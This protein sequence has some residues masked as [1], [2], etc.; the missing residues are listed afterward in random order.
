[1]TK[2]QL[3]EV[4]AGEIRIRLADI[5]GADLTDESRSEL[6]LLRTE[7][8]DVERRMGA[9]RI[10][11]TPSTPTSTDTSE[12]R[13]FRGLLT[14]ANAGAIF[15]SVVNHNPIAGET[16]ELQQHY[17]LAGNMVPLAL[18]AR[19]LPEDGLETRAA[20]VTNAPAD[21]GQNQQSI[22]PY[23][24][25]D[26]VGVFLGVD[27]PTVGVGETVFPVLTTA[28]D[29]HTP[30]EHAAAADTQHTFSADVLS[31]SRLQAAF[32]YSREDRARF[33]GM[34][35]ALRENLSMGL[36]DALDDEILTG[37]NG[38][39]TGTI[40]DNNNVSAV[41][42]YAL[43]RNQFV[44]GRV[45]GRYASMTG[46]LRIVMGADTYAHAAAQYRG[47]NDNT[48]ALMS[49]TDAAAGVRV[50]AHVP[51]TA[52]SKQ[53]A[54]I[55]LGMRRDMVVP[56]WEGVTLIPDEITQAAKGQIMVTA[57]MLH[58]V[59]VLRKGGFYKQQTQHA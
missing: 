12:G 46:D 32:L 7:Y 57:V 23:V 21:V 44:Y 1:M 14:R 27:M 45:D 29:V 10:S 8:T 25:P 40:L 19:N 35:A 18:L 36:S 9:L 58:A 42:T 5:A 47:N 41:T 20:G 51:A 48:D 13:E 34:D 55:R 6:E 59:K 54:V 53:N 50:S 37:T 15:D 52:S 22:I 24:F 56:T 3:L 43:Y 16:A 11:D 26:S 2:L 4:R 30:A 49:M 31:P 17:G 28:P 38:L 39:F 33:A